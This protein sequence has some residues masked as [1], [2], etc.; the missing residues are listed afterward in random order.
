MLPPN[1]ILNSK[2]KRNVTA[3]EKKIGAHILPCCDGLYK[4][5]R[6]SGPGA[7]SPDRLGQ[8]SISPVGNVIVVARCIIINLASN[9]LS[10]PKPS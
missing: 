2:I 3:R 8:F 7:L 10:R 9:I 4:I 1:I 6:Y 5:K